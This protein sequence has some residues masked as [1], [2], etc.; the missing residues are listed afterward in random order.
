M[1]DCALDVAGTLLEN[2]AQ[3]P[4]DDDC[5]WEQQHDKPQLH[6]HGHAAEVVY[7][8]LR[9]ILRPGNVLIQHQNTLVSFAARAVP[10]RQDI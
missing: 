2:G 3:A 9:E 6:K 7:C 5:G 8:E 4:T 10:R 1:K